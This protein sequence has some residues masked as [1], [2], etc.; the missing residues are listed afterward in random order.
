GGAGKGGRFTVCLPIR[1]LHDAVATGNGNGDH[2]ASTLIK[3]VRILV[4][5]DEA[6]ARE[7]IRRL[8]EEHEASVTTVSS[9][10]EAME[11]LERR[12]FDVLL[13]D[14]GMPELDGY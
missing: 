5:D 2:E 10:R 11:A 8:L 6:D 9:A 3:G 7:L 1:A 4:V 13:S 14:I 12:V